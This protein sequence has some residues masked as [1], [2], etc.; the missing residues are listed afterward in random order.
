MSDT[1]EKFDVPQDLAGCHALIEELTR[2]IS[3]QHE[4]I[5][6]SK[7]E[8]AELKFEM[9]ELIRR[10]MIKRAERYIEDPDQLKI[11]F[12]DTED[13]AD[14]VDG[15]KDALE[16]EELTIPEHTRRKRK[17]QP[18]TEKFPEHLEHR[19][20]EA[21]VPESLSHCQEHGPRKIIGYDSVETLHFQ[22]P[23]LWVEVTKYPKF[24]CEGEPEC[25]V[26]SPERP[27][28]LV[29]GNRYAPSVA[30]EVV[31][32][33]L[34]YHLP[35]YRQQNTFASC[36]WIPARS[37]LV[38]LF[39]A[40]A[41]TAKPLAKYIL[42]Q[43]LATGLVGT[44]ETRTTLLLP[45]D[46]PKPEDDLKSQR[47]HEV[48][49]DAIAE[50]KRSVSGR[51][52][53]YL[54]FTLPLNAFDF[55]V[56]RHRD[57]PDLVLEHFHGK[58]MADCYSGYQGIALRSNGR[59]QRAAC[60]THARRKVF[61]AR[62]E[63]PVESSFLLSRFVQ[64]YDI[65]T[66]AKNYD[67]ADRQELRMQEA[68]PI[69]DVMGEWLDGEVAARVLP[70]GNFGK[71]LGYLRNHWE[72]LQ[73]Y[74]TDGNLPIDNNDA[75]QLMKQ[76]AT[77]RKNWLF[78][79]SVAAGERMADLM[80]LV[81]SAIRNDLDVWAYLNDV[82]TRLLAGETDYE[83]LRPDIWRQSHP[84]AVREYRTEERRDRADRKQVRR[85]RRRALAAKQRRR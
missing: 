27:T 64:L 42:E 38:N 54:S 83:V 5:E 19:E 22:R 53:A 70:K 34:E 68:K 75:E 6:R 78:V 28:G 81:S 1:R 45:K 31:A 51:M 67:P 56:S 48:F 13:A 73:L 71:A 11:D 4:A 44:D 65:E 58:L 66:R 9:A 26:A 35:L 18:R 23:K 7:Q 55:T 40:A 16:E 62:G 61:E 79:G 60:A 25:G 85:A 12:G 33:K 52:W 74:L 14:A 24:A 47:I 43:I 82:L 3:E 80:T 39:A 2:R 10:A 46:I 29:E 32:S 77:G 57:G 84:E 41:F 20:V 72:P 17:R 8:I 21:D 76:I 36:G 69:W 30:A 50:G 63:Y 59:I 37:T 49:R 15:L